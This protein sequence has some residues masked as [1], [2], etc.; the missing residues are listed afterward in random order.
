MLDSSL[1]E[2]NHNPAREHSEN[3]N[4]PDQHG[5]RQ[6]DAL[7]G[8]SMIQVVDG[9]QLTIVNGEDADNCNKDYENQKPNNSHSHL[10]VKAR[11]NSR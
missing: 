6:M 8:K 7:N 1:E 10:I 2:T 5:H 4:S 9:D 11:I 3:I